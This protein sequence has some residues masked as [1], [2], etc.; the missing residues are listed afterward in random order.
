MMRWRSPSVSRT[1]HGASTIRRQHTL[2]HAGRAVTWTSAH[3]EHL[4]PA[5]RETLTAWEKTPTSVLL[6]ALS[7]S[8]PRAVLA[9]A[10][11]VLHGASS[12]AK[13][14]VGFLTS[15]LPASLVD[16][17]ADGTATLHSVAVAAIPEGHGTAF[18]SSLPGAARI[19]VGKWPSQKETWTRGESARTDQLDAQAAPS[20]QQ[21]WGKENADLRLPEALATIPYVCATYQCQG[22]GRFAVCQ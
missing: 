13:E 10:V 9:E 14:R 16:A 21:L 6:F 4:L 18:H 17:H 2:V 19:A 1:L 12:P 11:E 22:G 20:W 8:M 5:L 15:S 7:K 3:A